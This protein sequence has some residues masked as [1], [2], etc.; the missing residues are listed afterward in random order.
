MS[1]NYVW[2]MQ[3]GKIEALKRAFGQALL[4]SQLFVYE[5]L[6]PYVV[7][8][9][10]GCIVHGYIPTD[11]VVKYAGPGNPFAVLGRLF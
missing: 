9:V 3:V 6:W 11:F 8:G 5:E 2:E 4:C 1:R 10:G 7:I